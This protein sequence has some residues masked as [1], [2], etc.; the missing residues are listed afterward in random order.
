MEGLDDFR[1]D[2]ERTRWV[3]NT[4]LGKKVVAVDAESPSTTIGLILDDGTRVD[5]YP[6]LDREGCSLD[7]YTTITHRRIG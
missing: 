7:V 6:S 3:T 4:L 5:F 1:N 2:E